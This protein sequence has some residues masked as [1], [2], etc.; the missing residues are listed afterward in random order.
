VSCLSSRVGGRRGP[1]IGCSFSE[2]ES[3]EIYLSV[4][5]A[6]VLD[7]ASLACQLLG[8]SASLL[9]SS[10]VPVCCVG[11]VSLVQY[12]VLGGPS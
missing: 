3:L 5:L 11:Y 10:V 7:Y 8:A 9:L 6:A 12:C 4:L 1:I 2:G